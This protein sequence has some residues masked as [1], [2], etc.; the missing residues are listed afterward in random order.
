MLAL[1]WVAGPVEPAGQARATWHRPL[2][3]AVHLAVPGLRRMRL[4][5]W[6]AR[7]PL[8]VAAVH[9][10]VPPIRLLAGMAVW[11][12]ML[13]PGAAA[14]TA[15]VADNSLPLPPVEAEH[16]AVP[17]IKLGART[18][19]V[20]GTSRLLPSLVVVV[21]QVVALIKPLVRAARVVDNNQPPPPVEAEHQA[22]PLI[23]PGA[24]TAGVAGA[25]RLLP[26]VVAV[27][28]VVA[29]IK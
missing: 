18:A 17:L 22:V 5:V 6:A 20:A 21:E 14:G 24:Q 27:D 2:M 25:S 23:K 29:L 11:S 28:Q 26:P 13:S 16:P 4:A 1:V 9:Q 10:E 19:G 8:P 12:R 15:G 3:A 7:L